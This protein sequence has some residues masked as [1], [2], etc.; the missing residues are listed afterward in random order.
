MKVGEAQLTISPSDPLLECVLPVPSRLCK[1]RGPGSPRGNMLPGD[2]A[3]TLLHS[4]LWMPPGHFRFHMPN[5]YEE[6]CI[7]VF[8]GVHDLEHQEEVG[9][10]LHSG[11]REEYAWHP[12]DPLRHLLVLLVRLWWQMNKYSSHSLGRAW[13]SRAQGSLED[14]G[15]NHSSGK[16]LRP[17]RGASLG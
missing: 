7:T 4:K 6:E 12:G 10:L 11:G 15:M 5:G 8:A 1:V 16:P 3:R 2:T 14:E 17:K 13:G 9:L